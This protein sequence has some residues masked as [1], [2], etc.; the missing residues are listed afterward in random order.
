MAAKILLSQ[1]YAI[2]WDFV[3]EN[4]CN[5]E[6]DK[7]LSDKNPSSR[8]MRGTTP[9]VLVLVL[10]FG[11]GRQFGKCNVFQKDVKEQHASSILALAK[12]SLNETCVAS[13]QC[14]AKEKQSFCYIPNE[15]DNG[16]CECYRGYHAL[17]QGKKSWC[18]RDHVQKIGFQSRANKRKTRQAL[19]HTMLLVHHGIRPNEL[20]FLLAVPS[21]HGYAIE[22]DF[23]EEN[24]CNDEKYKLLSD[25]NPSSTKMRG[26]TPL[27]LVLV[28]LFGLGHQFGNCNI[29][30]KDAKEQHAS[31]I[32]ALAKASL[33]ETCVASE[34]C[35]AKEKQSFCYIPNEQDNGHCECYRGY[36]ALF[37]GKKSWCIRDHE[38]S[39]NET[40]V[41]SEQ[42][43]AK[44]KQSFCYIPNEQENGHCECYRGYH[45]LFQGKKSWCIRDHGH[46][47]ELS[48]EGRYYPQR[49]REQRTIFN[50]PNPRLMN[51]SLLPVGNAKHGSRHGS[52]MSLQHQKSHN[53]S[54]KAQKAE[55][56]K[57]KPSA[58][59]EFKQ[60]YTTDGAI[61]RV[62]N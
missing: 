5:D 56:G 53:G 51:T 54:N 16:H 18:I 3:E 26:T 62:S 32:L 37:Q 45:A 29:F 33:N 9:L 60:E 8:K 2:E 10:L 57:A 21:E 55:W 46:N 48:V 34:Q 25:K 39:L 14:S 59:E 19:I 6:K 12:A 22:W 23:V 43:S 27:V 41:A 36:H 24:L 31:S 17:F 35:S 42:C 61:D 40:C 15:Q 30:Q 38:A 28:L 52:S 49:F 47:D 50:T 7:L 11:L 44:E 58:T 13:E 4:L 1:G 20:L